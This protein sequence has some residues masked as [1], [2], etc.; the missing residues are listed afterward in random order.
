MSEGFVFLRQREVWS[1]AVA[2]WVYL[3]T[4][5]GVGS[6]HA[7]ALSSVVATGLLPPNVQGRPRG[8]QPAP[9]TSSSIRK[10]VLLKGPCALPDHL[11]SLGT[12]LG[13]R[14]DWLQ[15]GWGYIWASR[16]KE[17]GYSC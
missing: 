4:I 11:Y 9:T 10:T 16:K 5:L 6:L 14:H 1:E 12:W 3:L 15:T 8:D 7:F 17:V 2:V 13:Q